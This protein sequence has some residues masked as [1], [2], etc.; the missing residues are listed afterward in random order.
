MNHLNSKILVLLML[1]LPMISCQNQHNKSSKSLK[2]TNVDSTHNRLLESADELKKEQNQEI[3]GKK[4]IGPIKELVLGKT[5][6]SSMA[7]AGKK[8]YENNCASCHRIHK[9]LTGP[10][11]GS[12]LTR[13]SP[14]YVMNMILNTAEMIQKDPVVKS[15]LAEY[16]TKMVQVD[17]TKKEARQIVE[18]L[19]IAK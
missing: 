1:F 10:A 12:V 6:D 18:Y 8:L 3:P 13:R 9:S 2:K 7:K 5:I 16:G 11:L 4:G 15:L 19:R 14:E 17:V